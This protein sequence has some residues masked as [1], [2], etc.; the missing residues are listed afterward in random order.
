M[1]AH[2]RKVLGGGLTELRKTLAD[3]GVAEPLWYE[4]GKSK[5]APRFI[6]KAKKKGADLVFVWGGDGMVQRCV[7]ELAGTDTAI[8]ILP[9]GTANL[10]ATNLDIPDDLATAVRIGL[11]GERRVLDVG[12]LNGEHFAVMAGVGFD[13]LMIRDAG[14]G[15][16]D[17][18]GQLAYVWT[19][20]KHLRETPM[21]VNI[22][23]DGAKWFKGE[24]SCVL[25]GNVGKVIGGLSVFE[26][27]RPD[28]G[29]LEVGL[30]TAK[31]LVDWAR[32]AGR[33]ALGQP[34]A[35]PFV[36]TITATDIDVQ[37]KTPMVYELDGGD[38]KATKRLRIE[39]KPAAITV[40][41]PQAEAS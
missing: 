40:C 36:E 16:K 35:S 33:T 6:R 1:I 29:R 3:E 30:V 32:T 34:E 11:H 8:A 13:A 39:V 17:K 2:A 14:T 12:V 21:R 18:V 20:A 22:R 27:S 26:G 19:G 4:V 25:V 28:D 38:R 41:V 10:F 15:L 5:E 7:D 9:A 37:L 24:A 31:G 23:V